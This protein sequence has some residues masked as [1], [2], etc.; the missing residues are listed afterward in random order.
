MQRSALDVT[1]P[2]PKL[3]AEPK[4]VK[5]CV[6]R[7]EVTLNSSD[8]K[9]STGKPVS[10]PP[11][12][13]RELESY[14]D[15]HRVKALEKEVWQLSDLDMLPI[16]MIIASKEAG[17]IWLGAFE[18][19][20]LVGFAFGLLGRENGHYM[21][22]SHMLAVQGT[23]RDQDLGYRLKLAQRGRALAM[24]IRTMTW[25]FDPL[26]SRNA[27][28]NFAKLGVVSDK[29]K[30]DLYGPGTS[31]IL[32]R[33]STDRLWVQWRMSSK[34]VQQRLQ[35]KDAR[36]EILDVL[37]NLLPL[38]QFDPSGRPARTGLA[39]ALGR[40]R[41]CIEIPSDINLVEQEDPGLA[42][43]WRDATR[44]AFTESMKSGFVVTEFCRTIRG[45][46]GPGAYILQKGVLEEFVS[47]F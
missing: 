15:L 29:Y 34:R 44:W 22:H 25:T 42:K 1:F 45:K 30:I 3:L 16:T 2:Q 23:Y 41:V 37:P 8:P 19:E 13:I 36:A 10:R 4:M 40:Q 35:G 38:V 17:S 9:R 7:L 31:S 27:H 28:F 32:F 12:V 43:E 11:V 46:Q 6:L 47:D 26:Q 14:D 21:V 5:I 33:N 20:K 24:G 39:E 18:G